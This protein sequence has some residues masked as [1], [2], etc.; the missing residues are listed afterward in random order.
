[1]RRR[2]LPLLGA[3]LLLLLCAARMRAS[4][5]VWQSDATLWAHAATIAPLKPR[6]ALNYG[7]TLLQQR[8]YPQALTQLVR[9]KRL[10]GYAHVPSWDQAITR[11]AVAANLGAWGVTR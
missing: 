3:G 8:Q 1:M 10:T 2:H 11:R 9:A 4:L 5:L 6:V 7:V